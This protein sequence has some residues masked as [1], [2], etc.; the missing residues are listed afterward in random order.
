MRILK[1]SRYFWKYCASVRRCSGSKGELG[2]FDWI[3]A[4]QTTVKKVP[5]K[6]CIQLFKI[7]CVFARFELRETFFGDATSNKKI[8][9]W[10]SFSSWKICIHKTHCLCGCFHHNARTKLKVNILIPYLTSVVASLPVLHI[11][12]H[13]IFPVKSDKNAQ[14]NT[15]W[16]SSKAADGCCGG[17]VGLR[18]QGTNRLSSFQLEQTCSFSNRNVLTKKVTSWNKNPLDLTLSWWLAGFCTLQPETRW[19]SFGLL[20]DAAFAKKTPKK[21]GRLKRG[22]CAVDNWHWR[23]QAL[24]V[25]SGI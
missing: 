17:S 10:M 12:S 13:V 14:G 4:K 20:R 18:W 24:L 2:E 21:P 1:T 15:N 16:K 23:N 3:V 5:N 22:Y 6:W 8:W 11:C 19:E 7:N 9:S 25:F